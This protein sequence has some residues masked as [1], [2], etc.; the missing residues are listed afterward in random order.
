MDVQQQVDDLFVFEG[1]APSD[2]EP[3]DI[4]SA[5]AG[6]KGKPTTIPVSSAELFI[7]GTA[8]ISG[9][10]R[11]AITKA[12]EAETRSQYGG[13]EEYR[14]YFQDTEFKGGFSKDL[15]DKISE[16]SKSI[17]EGLSPQMIQEL[18]NDQSLIDEIKAIRDEYKVGGTIKVYETETRRGPEGLYTDTISKDVTVT[19]KM[20]QDKL[21]EARDSAINKKYYDTVSTS[22]KDRVM[23]MIPEE[24]RDDEDFLRLLTDKIYVEQQIDLDLD[25]N[26]R[27]KEQNP[28]SYLAKK[29]SSGTESLVQGVID[30]VDYTFTGGDKDLAGKRKE[31]QEKARESMMEFSK[32]ISSSLASGDV[33]NGLLQIGG[34]LAETAPIIAATAAGGIGGAALVGVSGAGNAYTEATNDPDF[35]DNLGGKIGYAIASGV[36]DFAFAAVGNSIFKAAHARAAAAGAE[37]TRGS[38][39]AGKKLTVDTLKAYARRKGVAMSSEAFEEAATEIATSVVRSMATGKEIDMN[40]LLQGLDAAIIGAAAGGVFDSLG[41]MNGKSKA[42]SYARANATATRA[43]EAEIQ[44]AKLREE[45][46]KTED[47]TER[48]RL[49]MIADG[50]TK[51][52]ER[53]R[54]ARTNFYDMLQARHPEAAESLMGMD[55][56]IESIARQM[57]Q[58]GISP[59]AKAALK[60]T[61]SLKSKQGLTLK[62]PFLRSL[63]TLLRRKETSFSNPQDGLIETDLTKTSSWLSLH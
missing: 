54:E 11:L 8:G 9:I 31:Q 6:V 42:M 34:G 1:G 27:I 7:A 51:D 16:E 18:N 62:E 35:G 57:Q 10:A 40:E 19:E 33:Y 2:S 32:G 15:A 56:E 30:A 41:S 23:E 39:M 13:L 52:A 55:I 45:A 29:M 43:V 28:F 53:S 59:E 22:A 36:G 48:R 60:S 21:Q 37:A 47:A 24:Y 63:L 44:A 49:L 61:L 14:K 12:Q 5:S 17:V 20:L 26:G 58:E 50:L 4:T 38:L 25:G 46:N 3:S